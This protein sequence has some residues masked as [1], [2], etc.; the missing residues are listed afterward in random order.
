M[1][2][3]PR[4]QFEQRQKKLEQ[5]RAL[6]FDPY[7]REFR[8]TETPAT[9]NEKY[10]GSSTSELEADKR[11]VRVAGRIVSYR[12]MGK[13]GFAHLQGSGKR[14]Q[15]YVRK[16]AVGDRGFELF[17]LLDL[18]DSVGVRGHMFRTNTN[19][20]SVWVEELTLLSKALLPLPEKWHGLTD[21]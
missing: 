19:E 10:Q 2:F 18:G 5:A 4:D 15:I 9:L 20:L 14:I 8:W 17:H 12:L 6:G 16:D 21:V 7:P 1:Q 11:E 3:E 13:A